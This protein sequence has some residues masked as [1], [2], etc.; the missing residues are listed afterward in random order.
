MEAFLPMVLH[1]QRIASSCD[2]PGGLPVR[3]QSYT[4]RVSILKTSGNE[5]YY[6]NYLILL[7]KMMLCSKLH[8][9]KFFKLKIFSHKTSH[10]PGTKL[11]GLVNGIGF[12]I[13]GLVW[14][15]QLPLNSSTLSSRPVNFVI[16]R[17]LF[18]Q[19]STPA[20]RSPSWGPS[21]S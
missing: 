2:A 12:P 11:S 8:C 7:I 6:T 14:S 17:R 5:V 15:H 13:S 3:Y 18:D 20:G 1:A 21:F 4:K 9:Q 10:R 19:S 16:T